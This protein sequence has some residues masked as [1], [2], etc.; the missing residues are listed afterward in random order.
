LPT[1][2]SAQGLG[3][4]RRQR[5]GKAGDSSAFVVLSVILLV[6]MLLCELG[7]APAASWFLGAVWVVLLVVR[8]VISATNK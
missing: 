3:G 2:A 8:V 4:H 6:L 5:E 7:G 1:A